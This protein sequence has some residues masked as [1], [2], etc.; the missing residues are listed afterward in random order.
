[1]TIILIVDEPPSLSDVDGSLETMPVPGEE[2]EDE[3]FFAL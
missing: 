3:D 2:E 1:M